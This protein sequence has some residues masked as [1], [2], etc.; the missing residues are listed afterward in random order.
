M[1]CQTQKVTQYIQFYFYEIS[2]IGKSIESE[3]RLVVDLEG[4]EKI[5]GD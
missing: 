2:G 3:S 5:N 4:M 1:K